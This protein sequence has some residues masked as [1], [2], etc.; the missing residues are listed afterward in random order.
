MLHVSVRHQTKLIQSC[1]MRHLNNDHYTTTFHPL[2]PTTR[3]TE[4]S[5]L[6]MHN[7]A[8]GETHKNCNKKNFDRFKFYNV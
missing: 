1:V 2:M 6:K 3:K 5:Y 7:T 8:R 4:R